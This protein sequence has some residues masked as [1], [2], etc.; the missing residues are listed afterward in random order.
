MSRHIL[1]LPEAQRTAFD[2]D[3]FVAHAAVLNQRHRL[4]GHHRPRLAG[5]RPLG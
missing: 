4:D 1:A 5:R 3:A 2:L